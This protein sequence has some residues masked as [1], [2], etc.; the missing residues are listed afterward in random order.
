M[1][2]DEI[3]QL[4]KELQNLQLDFNHRANRITKRLQTLRRRNSTQLEHSNESA[5]DT[6]EDAQQEEEQ[7]DDSR[8]RIGDW[9]K[10]TNNYRYLEKGVVGKVYKFNKSRDRLW[11]QKLDGTSHQR[12][13]WNVIKTKAPVVQRK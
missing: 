7:T 12:A 11:L 10:I 1:S 5:E 3:K 4:E 6:F 2:D 8:I 9:V 13:P